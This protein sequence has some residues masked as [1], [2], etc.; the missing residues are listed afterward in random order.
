MSR[1]YGYLI[2]AC[3]GLS[4]LVACHS[5]TAPTTTSTTTTT[6]GGTATTTVVIDSGTTTLTAVGESVQ[7]SASETLSDGTSQDITSQAT[8][9]SSSPTIIVVSATGVVTAVSLGQS[10]ITATFQ[11]VS[12]T[13]A[14]MFSLNLTGNWSG[15]GTDS[16]G[17]SQFTAVLTRSVSTVFTVSRSGDVRHR[18]DLRVQDIRCHLD[19]DQRARA[20]RDQRHRH[21]RRPA[22]HGVDQRNGAGHKQHVHL[23]GTP[24]RTRASVRS[25]VDS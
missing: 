16:T 20:L 3:I 5:A 24:A 23:V 9:T 12:G 10:T 13:S 22:L 17:T 2:I 8:W 7:L 21:T 11:G 19:R 4:S 18:R 14:V 6:A 25:P 1:R 15:T